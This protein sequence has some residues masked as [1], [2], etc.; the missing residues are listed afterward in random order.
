[1]DS[2]IP[3]SHKLHLP[4]YLLPCVLFFTFSCEVCSSS[5]LVI[6]WVI[7]TDVKVVRTPKIQ[8]LLLSKPLVLRTNELS[9]AISLPCCWHT[10]TWRNKPGAH[11]SCL[12]CYTKP[13]PPHFSGSTLAH[14]T[15]L[16][17]SAE[18]PLSQHKPCQHHISRSEALVLVAARVGLIS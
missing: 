17:P 18:V 14:H 3:F 5:L 11:T 9:G 15:C 7:Y 13:N 6:F 10:V 1:M 2:N 12:T 8:P 16:R 4:S